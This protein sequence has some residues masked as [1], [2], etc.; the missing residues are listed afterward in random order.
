MDT[1]SENTNE[2][3]FIAQFIVLSIIAGG[4]SALFTLAVNLATTVNLQLFHAKPFGMFVFIPLLFTLI[5]F[6]L[7]KYFE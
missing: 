1:V 6:L 5:S 7:K 3:K 4:V 2:K